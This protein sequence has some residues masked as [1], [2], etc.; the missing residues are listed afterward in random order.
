MGGDSNRGSEDGGVVIY[1]CVLVL[2][3]ILI[4]GIGSRS[5]LFICLSFFLSFLFFFLDLSHIL[6]YTLLCSALF[7]SALFHSIPFHNILF[8]II[9]LDIACVGSLMLQHS[10]LFYSI[11][12]YSIAF[13]S[14][15]FNSIF[16]ITYRKSN[17]AASE[18]GGIT[19]KLSAFSVKIRDR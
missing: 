19:Q 1:L 13:H 3:L 18:A 14:I 8:K 5:C 16:Y 17:V 15:L 7:C 2:N 6:I 9:L 10:I 4:L 12:F 11:L